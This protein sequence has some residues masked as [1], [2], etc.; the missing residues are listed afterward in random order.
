MRFVTR[1]LPA[2]I[3]ELGAANA[4][5]EA[6]A[7]EAGLDARTRFALQVALEEAF[8]NVCRYG[9]PDGPGDVAIT[10]ERDGPRF[11]LEV[12]D[13]GPPFDVL[14]LPEPDLTLGI[15]ERPI[16]G[17][18]VHLIRTLTH[19]VTYRRD[20]GRNVLRMQF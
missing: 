3:E 11:V 16:G 7:A 19:G 10:C 18:G 2:R 4:Y 13:W 17:L 8:V 20:A 5:V 6:C 1:H 9:Y 14:A 15:E 12:T